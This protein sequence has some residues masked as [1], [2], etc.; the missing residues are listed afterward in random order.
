MNNTGLSVPPTHALSAHSAE[1]FLSAEKLRMLGDTIMKGATGEEIQFFGEV[2]KR[3]GLDP[4]RKQI[5]A[6]KRWDG[7]ERREVWSFQTGVDGFRAIAH[8]SGACAGIDDAIFDP[9]DESTEFPR[10]ATV[11][12]YR[13]VGGQRVP[14]TAKARWNEYVQTTK[15]GK[16]TSMWFKLPYSQ[17]AK[18][19]ECLAL[20]KAFPE[21]L[22]DLRSNEEMA[23]ADNPEK[24]QASPYKLDELDTPP[25]QQPARQPEPRPTAGKVIE[26]A[27]EPVTTPSTP[28]SKLPE[29]ALPPQIEEFVGGRWKFYEL[30]ENGKKLGNL[31]VK[32]LFKLR[33]QMPEPLRSPI[34]ASYVDETLAVLDK[35]GTSEADFAAI[36]AAR[37]DL[38]I[39]FDQDLWMNPPIYPELLKLAQSLLAP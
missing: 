11:T 25:Q 26:A 38:D 27:A 15:E 16:I 32:M 19:A 2:C 3:T 12:V 30:P 22:S 9:A 13:I 18:C 37:A 31:G 21:D 10:S 33:E 7:K 23:Q 17:L 14:F 39:A 4:F 20:R 35:A 36:A 34:L 24:Q 6:V 8:R 5:H 29:F 28:P 1:A